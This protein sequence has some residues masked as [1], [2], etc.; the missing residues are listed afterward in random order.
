METTTTSTIPLTV[1]SEAE[2]DETTL[3]TTTSLTTT[4]ATTTTSLSLTEISVD[5]DSI[6]G[7]YQAITYHLSFF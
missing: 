5:T 2:F 6:N 3:G 7:F 4:T 1:S